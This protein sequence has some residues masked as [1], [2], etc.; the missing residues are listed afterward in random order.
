MRKNVVRGMMFSLK[1]LQKQLQSK[2][3]TLLGLVKRQIVPTL[4]QEL[5]K[6]L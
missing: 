3:A 1:G 5:G 4:V 2:R 6:T